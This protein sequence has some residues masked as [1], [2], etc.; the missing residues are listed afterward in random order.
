MLLIN[1]LR[2]RR[3]QTIGAVFA[4]LLSEGASVPEELWAELTFHECRSIYNSVDDKKIRARALQC[5]QETARTST[6][7]R[8][9]ASLSPEGLPQFAAQEPSCSY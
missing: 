2:R 1:Q 6:E 9:L 8:Y 5:M 3:N 7:K 4:E